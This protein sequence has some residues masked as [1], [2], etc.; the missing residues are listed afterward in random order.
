N[1]CRFGSLTGKAGRGPR[2][3]FGPRDLRAVGGGRRSLPT[4]RPRRNTGPFSAFG[5][6]AS[7]G[8]LID[9]SL[10]LGCCPRRKVCRRRVSRTRSRG[11]GTT[12][13]GSTHE[14]VARIRV[15]DSSAGKELA[16]R[17]RQISQRTNGGPCIRV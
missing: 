15:P 13:F 14:A 16:W 17:P 11:T 3:V 10:A 12:Q 9:C 4:H 2:T 7:R 6:P 5:L 1:L 8:C